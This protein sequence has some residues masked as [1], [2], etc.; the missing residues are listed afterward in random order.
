[1]RLKPV[2]I[3]VIIDEESGKLID[4]GK[5]KKEIE[6]MKQRILDLETKGVNN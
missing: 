5:L 2:E 6:T 3:R 4:V 1:M